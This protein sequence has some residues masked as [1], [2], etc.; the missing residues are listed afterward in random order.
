TQKITEQLTNEND[1][2]RIAFALH[3]GVIDDVSYSHLF[4]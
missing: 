3:S 4:P 1:H 2:Q